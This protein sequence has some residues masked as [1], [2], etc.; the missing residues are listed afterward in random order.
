MDAFVALD[1]GRFSGKLVLFFVA[2]PFSTL[3][4]IQAKVEYST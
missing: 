3:V 1:Y 2:Q 4:L